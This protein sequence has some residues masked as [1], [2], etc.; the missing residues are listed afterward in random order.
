MVP[1]ILLSSHSRV[2]LRID[3]EIRIGKSFLETITVLTLTTT[4]ICRW[5]H[6]K[7]PS[8][9]EALSNGVL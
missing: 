8:G 7:K 6:Q 5:I 1:V 2:G 9:T 4:L 3:Y